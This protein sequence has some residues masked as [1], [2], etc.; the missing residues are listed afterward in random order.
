[1]ALSRDVVIRLLGDASSAQAA[2]KAAADA[3]EVSV[4]QYRKAEREQAKQAAATEEASRKQRAAME[5]VGRGATVMGAVLVAGLGMA[6]KAAIDW[7]SSWA[8]VQKTM[9]A[10]TDFD[11]LEKDL[12]NLATTLPATHEEIAG[13]AEAAGQ[14]GI[15]SGS[16]VEF[17]KT[18]IALGVA[19][20]L[21]AEDAAT[22]LARFSNIMGTSSDDVDRLGSSLVALGNAG[23]STESEIL[24]MGN[25]IA[26]AGAQSH[27]TEGDVLGIANAMS[28]LGIE[29]EAGGTAI[30]TVIK[31]INSDVISGGGNLEKY[32]A[33]AG[34]SA[35]QFAKSW[36]D[37]ASG[38]L[39]GLLAG[40]GKVQASGGDLNK[41]LGDLGWSDIRVSDTMLR[42]AGNSQLLTN[43]LKTGNDGWRENNALTAEAERRY[44]TTASRLQVARNQIN[45]AA[46]D[47]GGML[48]PV[49]ASG[50]E[51]VADFARGFSD[52]PGPVKTI[53]EV[54][55]AATA[56]ITLLGGAALL[57]AP[58]IA[59]FKLAVEAL[60]EGGSK[61]GKALGG[62]A[63]FL[64][65]P[66]GIAIGI[67]SMLLGG[68]V[69][70]LGATSGAS[71]KAVSSTKDLASA[72]KATNGVVNDNIRTMAAQ[73]AEENGLLKLADKIGVS[74]GDIVK[75][76]LHEGNAYD[77]VTGH[78]KSYIGEHNRGAV[79]MDAMSGVM[80]DSMDCPGARRAGSAQRHQG[81]VRRAG[82]ERR[83]AGAGGRGRRFCCR[84]RRRSDVG[85]D[86]DRGRGRAQ[87]DDDGRPAYG[88]L[89]QTGDSADDVKSA[90]ELL[91]EALDGLNGPALNAR[92]AAR[93]LE[94]AFDAADKAIAENGKTLD[95]HTEKGRN[96]NEALDGIATAAMKNAQAIL[97]TGGSYEQFRNSLETSRQHLIDTAKQM[98]ATQGDAEALANQ[99]LQIPDASEVDV[100]MPT[101]GQ[102]T[103]QLTDVATKVH[104]IPPG[105][106]VNIGVLSD[107][108]MKALRD[109]GFTVTTLPDGTVDVTANTDAAKTELNDFLSTRHILTVFGFLNT[110]NI[111]ASIQ[112]YHG[113][114]RVGI[115]PR[116]A[117]GPVSSG[118]TYLVGERGPELLRMGGAG[119]VTPAGL[120]RTAVTAAAGLPVAQAGRSMSVQIDYARLGA[121]V[122]AA[123]GGNGGGLTIQNYNEARNSPY[124]TAEAL[125]W[126]ARTRG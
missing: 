51:L 114:V 18:A 21:S 124:E 13:V 40:M 10:G 123:V 93:Q 78:L 110:D 107:A 111:T 90:A 87:L 96:N 30:S 36:K 100:K 75:A 53:I 11:A 113:N 44:A 70:W 108:A 41:T 67:G 45:D 43:S 31:N 49:L 74:R 52:L 105:K 104:D 28:S 83:V 46:I 33:I 73:Q 103:Q 37:D 117:G 1:V 91:G 82:R 17:T 14:L 63:S 94:E 48:L 55:G 115:A 24:T 27:M 22:G 7:E 95:I 80:S 89:I 34:V 59:A 126:L 8:G 5:S 116:A 71:D 79:S 29:A 64:T 3:A 57:A 12:R 118:S 121:A 19:T 81:P 77:T 85:A 54:I 97:D 23:A 84:R 56:A 47:I 20:N 102:I 99:I 119:Y 15:S 50:A 32:A 61:A 72:L 6:A 66:W 38:A 62:F 25:R 9:D 106:T 98:G 112:Q 86:R 76:M 120:T 16:I 26:A 122:A 65:G 4:A 88:V 39:T 68:L 125:S 2:L 92:D 35:Q 69:T 42:L 60:N 101:Y 109:L 58:K